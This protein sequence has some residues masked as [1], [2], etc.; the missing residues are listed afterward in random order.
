MQPAAFDTV[1]LA[2]GLCME[3]LH[4]NAGGMLPAASA[5][6]P[7]ANCLPSAAPPPTNATDP[8]VLALA[9][10]RE[11]AE[12]IR[13]SSQRRAPVP[14]PAGLAAAGPQAVACALSRA[15][16][17][18]PPGDGH[19]AGK[20]A[21]QRASSRFACANWCSASAWLVQISVW[22]QHQATLHLQPLSACHW[23]GGIVRTSRFRFG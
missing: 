13:G 11:Y 20:S 16:S 21:T 3:C 6:G 8:V 19:D 4:L 22:L 5:S 15:P 10:R 12:Q 7:G 14:D 2:Q 18:V 23:L 9:R 1:A 17:T